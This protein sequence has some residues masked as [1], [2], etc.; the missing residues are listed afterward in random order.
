MN[1]RVVVTG[2]GVVSPLGIGLEQNW[3]ALCAGKS[4]VGWITRF[5]A[6]GFRTRVAGEVK[7]FQPQDFISEKISR[8][9]DRFQQFAMAAARMALEDSGLKITSENADRVGTSIGTGLGG[10]ETTTNG[11]VMFMNGNRSSISPFF[12]PMFLTGMASG[13]IAMGLGAKGPNF[14]STTACA[15]GTHAVGDAFRIIQRGEADAMLAG[16]S[17]APIVPILIHSLGTMGATTGRSDDPAKACRPFDADRDGFIPAEGGA[18]LVLE[19]LESALRRDAPIYGEVIGY[20]ATCD[21]YHVTSPSPGGEGALRCMKLALKDAGVEP[22]RV[23]YINA[24]GTSTKL[25][26]LTE[27]QAIKVVFGERARHIPASSNKSMIGHTLGASGA[28]EAIMTLLTIR[29]SLLPPTVNLERPDPECDLD[30]VPNVARKFTVNI[31]ISNSFGFGGTNGVIVFRK[32]E[33]K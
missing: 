26:D 28:V 22:D 32:Y 30:Y 8:R 13:Q 5:D 24:H 7:D 16:G 17:E 21:A 6:T 23:D 25:N 12:V 27:T 19:D 18:V 31:A 2:A 20:A 29:N 10:I 33:A 14:S 15:A 9:T 3:Q 4:G 11:Q 1:R